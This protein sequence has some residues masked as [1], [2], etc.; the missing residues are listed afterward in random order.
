MFF[1][2]NVRGLNGDTRHNSVKDWIGKNK[3]IFGALLETRIQHINISRIPGALPVGWKFFANSDNQM[4]A[5]IVVVWHPSVSV[6][7]YKATPQVVTCGIFILAEN[8]SLT[9]SFVYGY[10]QVENRQELWNE[11]ACL[12]ANT[13]VARCPWAVLGDF[14]QIL[15]SEQHSHHLNGEVDTDGMEDFNLALQEAELFEAQSNGLT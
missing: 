13:P 15:R 5:R 7:I 1:A 10:N 14:N 12:N 2:W 11:L 6:T 8:L 3:P 4:S 9:V